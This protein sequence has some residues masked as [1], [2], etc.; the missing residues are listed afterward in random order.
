M[1]PNF[2]NQEFGHCVNFF[3]Q[4]GH[5]RS[6]PPPPPPSPPQVRRCPYAYGK[7]VW[8]RPCRASPWS[9]GKK[10]YSKGEFVI[11]PVKSS[12]QFTSICRF[13]KLYSKRSKC[14]KTG[15]CGLVGAILFGCGAF[16]TNLLVFPLYRELNLMTGARNIYKGKRADVLSV[17]SRVDCIA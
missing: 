9:N 3:G 5:R 16:L 12:T 4:N 10:K 11:L 1:Y 2:K 14:L 6:P 7:G 8:Q 13:T 15:K 17:S